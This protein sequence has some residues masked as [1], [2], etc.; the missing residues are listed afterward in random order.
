[1]LW[2][3]TRPWATQPRRRE[4]PPESADHPECKFR[5]CQSGDRV[6]YTPTAFAPS[7]EPAAGPPTQRSYRQRIAVLA[8]IRVGQEPK[9]GQ[10]HADSYRAGG[11]EFE[12]AFEC[13]GEEWGRFR[14]GSRHQDDLA[15]ST[16][17]GNHQSAARSARSRN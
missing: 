10:P 3:A 7:D 17:A 5:D 2:R 16:E 15:K 12:R 13:P 4:R 1:M 14:R 8:P 9:P 6:G 11:I